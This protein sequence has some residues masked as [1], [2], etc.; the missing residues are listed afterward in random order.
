MKYFIIIGITVLALPM[1]MAQESGQRY[2]ETV[3]DV[4]SIPYDQIDEDENEVESDD[5][6][7]DLWSD[8]ENAFRFLEERSAENELRR[9]RMTEISKRLPGRRH[10]F[11]RFGKR[12]QPTHSFVR[13]GRSVTS[14]PQQ[15]KTPDHVNEINHNE[16]PG[17]FIYLLE[18]SGKYPE[19][20]KRQHVLVRVGHSGQLVNVTSIQDKVDQGSLGA[21]SDLDSPLLLS[22]LKRQRPSNVRI[23]KLPASLYLYS[24]N[25]TKLTSVKQDSRKDTIYPRYG[26]VIVQSTG[27]NLS[28]SK[29]IDLKCDSRSVIV[30]STGITLVPNWHTLDF[31]CDSRSGMCQ[32]TE[33]GS[34]HQVREHNF[35]S[36]TET[37]S[38]HQVQRQEVFIRYRDRKC[39]SAQRQEVFIRYRD[40][41]CSSSTETGSVHQAQRQEVFIKY[42][43]RKCSSSTEKEVF[44]KYRDRKCSSGTREEVFLKFS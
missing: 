4:N 6:I 31:K 23:G 33:T 8:I 38:V 28:N 34:V 15:D 13:F 40:R 27:I 20:M 11:I 42:R 22:L 35:S 41:K 18:L 30:Q 25:P 16:T 32:S 26:S 24:K 1:F 14:S 19:I 21:A 10:N 17:S 36:G 43:D 29:Y 37:E 5:Y 3:H 39:S 2:Q 9:I 7:S 12:Y 44:I